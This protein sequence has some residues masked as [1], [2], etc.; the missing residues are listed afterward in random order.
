MAVLVVEAVV[1]GC[2]AS[3]GPV[4]PSGGGA[5]PGA[6]A[7]AGR[8]LLRVAEVIVGADLTDH[9]RDDQRV[10]CAGAAGNEPIESATA[11]SP[12]VLTASVSRSS[13]PAAGEPDRTRGAR[14]DVSARLAVGMDEG[15]SQAGRW[16]LVRKSDRTLSVFDANR[17]LKT[18]TVVLGRDPVAPKLYEGDRRTP[19]GSYR[20]VSKS[21]HRAWQRFLL[22]DYPNADNLEDYTRGRAQGLVPSRNGQ[23]AGTGGAV[24]IH[25][26]ED[27]DLNRK[28][29]NW[30]Y[31]C[32][33]LVS[34]DIQELYDL[35]SVGTPVV[36]EH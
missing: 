22:L 3:R 34:R 2:S 29:V 32:I 8:V 36:I 23:V 5:H 20:V 4:C 24:G 28:G 6:P 26:T 27:D 30:T 19:E 16:I 21:A 15:Q 33:S 25:G 9:S 35:V 31:G 1:A 18:Y 17:P 13:R 10:A 7:V 14:S 11:A 12:T